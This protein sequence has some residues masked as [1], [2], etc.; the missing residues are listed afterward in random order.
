LIDYQSNQKYHVQLNDMANFLIQVSDKDICNMLKERLLFINKKWKSIQE[1]LLK[2][3]KSS[4]HLIK[5][6]ECEQGCLN[7][8]EW[9]TRIS[10]LVQKPLK[11]SNINTIIKYQEELN[12]ANNDLES[13]DANLVLLNKLIKRIQG[14][15]VKE[16]N[17]ASSDDDEI[18]TENDIEKLMNDIKNIEA[19]LMNFRKTI[20][21]Y[22]KNLTKFCTNLTSIEDAVKQTNHWINEGDVI[23]RSQPDQLNFE[24]ITKH[25]DKQKVKFLFFLLS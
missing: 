1:V 11:C 14:E 23:L 17:E 5:L 19:R 9:L 22:L 12:K 13:I 3:N 4:E 10:N 2:N 20:P 16:N 18:I 7:I 6:I 24:Q 21:E 8:N 25:I 15:Y